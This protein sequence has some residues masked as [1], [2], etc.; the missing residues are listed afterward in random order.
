MAPNF[1]D[2]TD[3]SYGMRQKADFLN[4]QSSLASESAM[5]LLSR[6]M[7]SQR[8]ISPSQGIAAALLAAIPTLGGYLM[9]KSIGGAE[10]PRIGELGIAP[11]NMKYLSS[12]SLNMF[13]PGKYDPTGGYAGGL[14]GAKIGAEASKDYTGAIELDNAHNQKVLAAKAQIESQR[15]DQLRQ[16]ANT[17]DNAALEVDSKIA[18][19]PIEMREFEKKQAIQRDMQIAA[20]NAMADSDEK[21]K[22]LPSNLMNI[23][24]QMEAAALRGDLKNMPII[25]PELMTDLTPAQM[26]AVSTRTAEARRLATQI[27]TSYGEKAAAPTATVYTKLAAADSAEFAQ[28]RLR[29]LYNTAIQQ[30]GPGFAQAFVRQGVKAFPANAQQEFDSVLKSLAMQMNKAVDPTPSDAGMLAQYEKLKGA[31][32]NGHF[33]QSLDFE[34]KNARNMALNELRPFV[35]GEYPNAQAVS[36]FESYKNKWRVKPSKEEALADLDAKIAALEAEMTRSK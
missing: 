21:R 8:D 7:A 13:D 11:E 5:D 15:A 9:G 23:V 35:E 36:L 32:D 6:S 26:N 14:A 30:I 34:V 19:L 2:L 29:Q 1:L 16:Q 17:V 10:V 3:P 4:D 31:I 33:I 28:T 18:M 22:A 27:K 25:P 24:S 20:H 12:S